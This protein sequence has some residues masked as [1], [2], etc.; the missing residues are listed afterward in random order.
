MRWPRFPSRCWALPSASRIAVLWNVANPSKATDWRAAQDAARTLAFNLE[1]C[2]FTGPDDLQAALEVARKVK[3]DAFMPLEDSL[4]FRFRRTIVDF[5]S[6]ARLPAIYAGGYAELGGLM[7]YYVNPDEFFRLNAFYLDKI[8]RGAKPA[9]LP[10]AQATRLR[11]SVN[12]RTAKALDV[13]IPQTIL[14]RADVV[15][16]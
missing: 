4:T 3:A 5:A 16:R 11:L 10:V 15:I 9:D 8:L 7:S 13:T 14:K 12:L 6:S 1:P 2:Q